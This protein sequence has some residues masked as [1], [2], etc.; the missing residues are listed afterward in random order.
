MEPGG[1]F[2][3]SGCDKIRERLDTDS[4]EKGVSL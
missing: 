1:N 3:A 2:L 4:I